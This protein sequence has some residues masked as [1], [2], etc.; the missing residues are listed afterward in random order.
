[1]K[2]LKKQPALKH[3]LYA[4]AAMPVPPATLAKAGPTQPVKKIRKGKK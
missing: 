3:A 2:T 1:M 4:K